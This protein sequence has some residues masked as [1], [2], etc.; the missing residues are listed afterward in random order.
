MNSTRK[1]SLWFHQSSLIAS[2]YFKNYHPHSSFI[3]NWL[4]GHVSFSPL[5]KW[6]S[7]D[8]PEDIRINDSASF[9]IDDTGSWVP[10]AWHFGVKLWCFIRSQRE[11]NPWHVLHWAVE[12]TLVL[13]TRDCDDLNVFCSTSIPGLVEL[14]QV[15]LERFAT[16]SPVCCMKNHDDFVACNTT[17]VEFVA[18]AIDVCVWKPICWIHIKIF[19]L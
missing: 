16:R 19:K 4:F 3:L 7:V 18:F 9:A 10:S 13:V 15:R 11:S 17:L 8:L 5:A 1:T 6:V 2:N 14:F 12:T